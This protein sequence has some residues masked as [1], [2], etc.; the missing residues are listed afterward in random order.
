MKIRQDAADSGSGDDG[1]VV[2]LHGFVIAT[3][4]LF[5][6]IMSGMWLDHPP[7]RWQ[8][9]QSFEA[10]RAG[11]QVE[12]KLFVAEDRLYSF[13][14]RF[15]ARSPDGDVAR[16]TRPGFITAAPQEYIVKEKMLPPSDASIALRLRID[17]QDMTG[18]RPIVDEI[19]H[20]QV[21]SEVSGDH[22]SKNIGTIELPPGYYRLSIQSLADVAALADTP[23][24]VE[25]SWSDKTPPHPEQRSSARMNALLG[26][27][28]DE[29]LLHHLGN[30]QQLP[31]G[32]PPSEKSFLRMDSFFIPPQASVL[33]ACDHHVYMDRESDNFW[34]V[35]RCKDAPANIFRAGGEDSGHALPRSLQAMVFDKG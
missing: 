17:V 2:N 4:I 14:L 9:V 18:E 23:L 15:G 28:Q 33:D 21:L 10:A 1:G 8:R 20:P 24:A 26:K 19:V 22:V 16:E 32:V 27:I 31:R 30:L 35:R 6:W 12:R 29:D 7:R 13:A 3:L 5:F 34:I 11:A 25:I